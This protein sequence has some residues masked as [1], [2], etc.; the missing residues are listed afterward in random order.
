MKTCIVIGAHG[1]IGS[2]IVAEA[3][4][5]GYAVTA[6]DRDN[7]EAQRGASATLLIN[8]NGNS[9]KFIDERDPAQ[10]FE[11]SVSSVLNALLDFKFDQYI[12]ISSGAIYPR[13][14]NPQHNR[15]D[16]PL[17]PAGMSPYGFHKWL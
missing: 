3:Q 5:R 10:G 6:V 14:D 11:L 13:E 7:Y 12:Q 9:R 2:A 4:Q 15:E 1:F 16:T 17:Q 8:A